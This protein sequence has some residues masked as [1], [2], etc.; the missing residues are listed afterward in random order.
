MDDGAGRPRAG[1]LAVDEDV[2]IVRSVIRRLALGVLR[3]ECGLYSLPGRTRQVYGRQRL[4]SARRPHCQPSVSLHG[5]QRKGNSVLVSG[6]HGFRQ[7][8][9]GDKRSGIRNLR[10]RIEDVVP[11]SDFEILNR[12]LRLLSSHE[13]LIG[14]LGD[15][16]EIAVVVPEHRMLRSQDGINRR[17]HQAKQDIGV[18]VL[19]CR[20]SCREYAS[21][22]DEHIPVQR[23]LD[24]HCRSRCA[25]ETRYCISQRES[26]SPRDVVVRLG[27]RRRSV[28]RADIKNGLCHIEGRSRQ[29]H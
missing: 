2:P 16:L 29:Q 25:R 8:I 20:H 5:C 14:N 11:A 6:C 1:G 21:S 12:L 17:A 28:L 4:V 10:A 13:G 26:C 27:Q 3:D 19:C 18:S 22:R 15:G 9:P 24:V 23:A 7:S